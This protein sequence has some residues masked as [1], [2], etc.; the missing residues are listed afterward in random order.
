MYF[1]V[2]EQLRLVEQQTLIF[3]SFTFGQT[4][5]GRREL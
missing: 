1:K 3:H 4:I 5:Y 2:K